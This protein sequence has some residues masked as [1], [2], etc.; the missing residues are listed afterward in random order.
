MYYIDKTKKNVSL[1][2][3]FGAKDVVDDVMNQAGQVRLVHR[4]YLN[5]HILFIK[6]LTNS[7][8][9]WSVSLS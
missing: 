2:A 3:G 4:K 5:I 6:I 9:Y 1:L 7:N 8:Q